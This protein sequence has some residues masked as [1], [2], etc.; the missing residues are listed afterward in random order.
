M[1]YDIEIQR[2]CTHPIPVSDTQ[3]Q[4]WASRVLK[5]HQPSAELTI[6]LAD[7]AEI[8]ELNA[9]YREKNKETNV[10]SF[11]FTP[12][13]GVPFEVPY[14]G[15]IIISPEVLERE[16]TEQNKAPAAH[17]AHI[18]IHGV[19]HLLGYDHINTEDAVKMEGFEIRLLAELNIPNPYVTEGE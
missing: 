7:A 19:L 18:V 6:R 8:Q 11:P 2:D 15:D 12:P 16:Y 14:L 4:E 17:W 1:T 9:T 5:E 3:I 13:P 10:L